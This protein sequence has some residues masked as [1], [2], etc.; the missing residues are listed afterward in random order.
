MLAIICWTA[1][2]SGL[3]FYVMKRIGWLRVS[4]LDEIIGL[5]ITEMG[6]E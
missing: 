6:A 4:L 5:D 1:L 3:Y 2:F